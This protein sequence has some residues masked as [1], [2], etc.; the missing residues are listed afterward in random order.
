MKNFIEINTQETTD[1][2]EK[3]IAKIIGDIAN[4]SLQ[5]NVTHSI[6]NTSSDFINDKQMTM[7]LA[8]IISDEFMGDLV[9]EDNNIHIVLNTGD[10]FTIT[11]NRAESKSHLC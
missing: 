6:R 2:E 11:I 8:T 7:D 3:Q 4:V 1:E 9:V 10:S 5:N